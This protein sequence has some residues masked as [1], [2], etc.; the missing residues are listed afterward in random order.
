M[1]LGCFQSNRGLRQMAYGDFVK[2][3]RELGYAAFDVPPGDADAVE[4]CLRSGATIH[5]TGAVIPPDLSRDPDVQQAIV[6]QMRAAVESAAAH[7]IGVITHL[8]G[9]DP[10]LSG[11]ENIAIFRDVYTPIAAHAEAT[12]VRLAFE[13]WPRNGTML[14]IT[15]EMWDAMFTAVPSSALGLCYDPSHFYWL[16]IDYIQ[17]IFDFADRVYHAHAKDT[18]I[19][20]SGRNYYGIYG[21]QLSSTQA[22]SWWRYRLPGYGAVDWAKYLDALYQIGYD[23]VLSVEHEDP[24]WSDTPEQ[25]LRGLQLSR[26]FLRRSWLDDDSPGMWRRDNKG[27]G[28]VDFSRPF[29]G[30]T[31]RIRPQAMPITPARIRA[32]PPARSPV[33]PSPCRSDEV[34]RCAVP[35]PGSA[36]STGPANQAPGPG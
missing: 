8:V 28:K 10:S 24:V 17:P 20:A 1:K 25:A 6:S 5:A 3:A 31:A 4:L 29:W 14:A 26:Q 16:G 21:R 22:G 34:G 9:R 19:L 12:G 32:D 23:A 2:A 33:P 27:P 18:E 30:S 15:P 11:D 7:D 35:D 13:N 36:H